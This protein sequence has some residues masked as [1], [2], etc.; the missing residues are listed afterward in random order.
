VLSTLIRYVLGEKPK[1]LRFKLD[2]MAGEIHS[3]ASVDVEKL[4][5]ACDDEIERAVILVAAGAGLRSGVI[6][7]LRWNDLKSP[8]RSRCHCALNVCWRRFRARAVGDRRGR[9]FMC[10][11]RPAQLVRQRRFATSTSAKMTTRSCGR[12]IRRRVR[13]EE[14]KRLKT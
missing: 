4:L 14:A 6:R 8:G 2:G 5:D 13:R 10:R 3:V 9:R 1:Y 11:I 12:G 7:G